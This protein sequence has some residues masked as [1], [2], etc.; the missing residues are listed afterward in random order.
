MKKLG[1]LTFNRA[2]NYGAVLQ[3]YALKSVCEDLGYETHVIDYNQG[4]DDGPHPIRSFIHSSNK[5]RASVRLLKNILSYYWDRKRW[6]A[7]RRFRKEYLDESLPCQQASEIVALDYDA[8]VMG[9]DQ[10]WNYQITGGQFDPVYFGRLPKAVVSVVYAAS[11]HDTPFP[12]DME[13]K[14]KEELS[15][16]QAPIGIREQ[17]LAEYAGLLTGVTYPVVVDPTLLAGREILERVESKGFPK[18]PYILLYQIDHNPSSDIS[19]RSLGKKFGCKVY[20]MTVPKLG[21]T[22]GKR[23]GLGPEE[24]LSLL[25]HAE[26]LV[27]NSFHGVALSLLLHKQFYVYE[28]G[29]VMTRIDGL[30]DSLN[31][32]DRKVRLVSDINLNRKIDYTLVDPELD[33][34][35]RDSLSFLKKGLDGDRQIRYDRIPE[36]KPLEGC[37]FS[38]RE[39]KDCSGCTA[40]VGICPVEAISMKKDPEGFLYPTI[41]QNSC[42][43]CGACDKFCSFKTVE[44]RDIDDLPE[45][46]GVKHKR[47]A[48]RISSR[49]G[50]AF[51]A[52]SDII[53]SKK[54]VIYG[55]AM[56]RNGKVGHIRAESGRKRDRMKGAKYVQSDLNQTFKKVSED[57]NSGRKVL[58]SGTPCQVAGLKELLEYKKID[59][60]NLLTCDLVCHGVPSPLIWA[61]YLR[62]IRKKHHSRII[63]A[64]FRDKSFG[65]DTHC[66]SFVLENGKKIVS[67]DYTDLFY[68][69]IMFR[70]SCHNC[71]YAN[72]NRVGDITLADFWGVEKS[73]PA[74]A[75]SKGVSLVL[76][77]SEMG[78]EVFQQASKD[79]QCIECDIRNC[80]QPTLV[81]P[82][83]PSPLR[84]VFWQNYQEK[85]FEYALKKYKKS[86]PLI[87]RLK[88]DTKQILYRMRLRTHP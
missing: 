84:E 24:F 37:S 50:G 49:S 66:E 29:G 27:T 53:L 62:Y 30:L 28:N 87:K 10:I 44:R 79:L 80:I 32:T 23:G 75:D 15:E 78:K 8:Y 20:S 21:S 86:L 68:E 17:K 61:D 76:V 18:K 11:A 74:F 57:L 70:P 46:Y 83:S 33:R 60:S 26:F 73:D 19:I 48:T 5:K 40:C 12:L 35:R 54:G 34:L 58:F 41:D 7:F 88:K 42:V 45:A 2:L 16:A 13:L 64:D 31:L 69:H 82:S 6:K 22:H 72:V 36:E 65:W 71:H 39:K 81:K 56:D 59:Q 85:G 14:L 55:A 4:M 38:N 51:I 52:I 1:I 25:D 67:R 77:N 47:S 63:T 43:H 3:A 9:S